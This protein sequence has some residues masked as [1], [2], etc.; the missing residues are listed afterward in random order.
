MVIKGFLP[1]LYSGGDGGG[2]AT[3]TLPIINSFGM[4]TQ[5]IFN[6]R[7]DYPESDGTTRTRL[8]DLFQ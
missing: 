4:K 7:P 3:P 8:E 6:S 5:L 1:A 2:Y